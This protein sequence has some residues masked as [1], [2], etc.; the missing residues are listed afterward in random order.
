M[1]S[2][3]PLDKNT[4]NSGKPAK[5]IPSQVVLNAAEG[6]ETRR[7]ESITCRTCES[8]KPSTEF[9][10]KDGLASNRRDVICKRCRINKHRE[11]IL[12][13]S[14]E[15]YTE[16]HKAQ[17]G[18]CGLCKKQLRSRRYK[19]FSVDHCRATGRIRGLLCQLCNRG[20]GFFSDDVE[21]LQRAI[22]WVK[23]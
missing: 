7:S 8:S 6:V 22:E 10:L 14:P 3:L 17:K 16:M 12:G 15:Q 11:R 1:G 2:F 9:Y 5:A 20:L 13:V 18:R 19:Q 21:L 4:P 23:G